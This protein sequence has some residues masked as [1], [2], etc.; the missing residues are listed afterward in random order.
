[1]YIVFSQSE[2]CAPEHSEASECARGHKCAN[3]GTCYL[4]FRYNK[5]T[6]KTS[7]GQ[8]CDC[9]AGYTGFHC[10]FNERELEQMRRDCLRPSPRVLVKTY[11]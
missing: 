7:S 1:M 10:Q 3:N 8:I 2:P 5:E 9:P 11:A 4:R 6:N